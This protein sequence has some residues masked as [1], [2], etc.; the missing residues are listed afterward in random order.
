[1]HGVRRGVRHERSMK[2][3]RHGKRQ[4]GGV[5]IRRELGV[6][7]IFCGDVMCDGLMVDVVYGLRM[8]AWFLSF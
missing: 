2:E 6:W 5:C 4:A 1:M 8:L 7:L 3:R